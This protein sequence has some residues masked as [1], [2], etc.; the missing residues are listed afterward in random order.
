MTN[1]DNSGVANRNKY[2]SAQRLLA[3]GP[4]A[5]T[6]AVLVVQTI[7]PTWLSSLPLEATSAVIAGSVVFLAWH[8][9]GTLFESANAVRTLERRVVTLETTQDRFI[10]S[11]RSLS[12]AR[13]A[14]AFARVAAAMP[15]VGYLRIFAISSQQI[16]SFVKFHD[17]YIDRCDL[18]V[19]SFPEDDEPHRA[20]LNQIRLVVADWRRLQETGRIGQ[21]TIRYYDFHP[22][23]YECIFDREFMMLGLYDSDPSD[24]S[25]VS[26]RD[27]ILVSGF[28][29]G[30]R[31][32]ISEFIARYDNL[33]ETCLGHHGTVTIAPKPNPEA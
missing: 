5:L 30:G 24:Y 6:A 19:R 10:E 15:R 16:L 14:Q 29:E 28:A 25:E 11:T 18:L 2:R 7:A 13:L 27:P 17:M 20:F 23:E 9:E 33:F 32:M 31:L 26:V 1:A 21:L 3:Y 12:H 8:L 22:T 4:L